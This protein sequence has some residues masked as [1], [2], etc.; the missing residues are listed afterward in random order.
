[1]QLTNWLTTAFAVAMVAGPALAAETD[2]APVE[3]SLGRMTM[4]YTYYNR[5]G[6]EL[7][8]HD[9]DVIA[10]AADAARMLSVDEAL[11]TG[12]AQGLV[13]ALV[14]GAIQNAAHRGA[15]AAGL[16]NCMVVRGWR[17]VKLGDDEGQ[18]LA[19]LPQADLAAR[20][21]PWI[22]AAVP[23]GQIVRVWGNDAANA[24][25]HRYAMRP[26]HTNNGQL[27]LAEATTGD[28]HQFET[29]GRPV[30]SARAV[31]DPKWPKKALTA[32]TL[33]AAPN[34]SGILM[35]RI[36]GLSL[37]NGIGVWLSREGADKDIFPSRSDHGPDLL[38]AAKGL[39][40]AHH[41]GDMFV[42]ATP[43]GRWRLAAIGMTPSL[44]LCLGSPSFAVGAGEVVYA[45][46]FDLGAADF[47]PDLDL[48][49]AKA[50]LAG[51]PQAQTVRA[52][53]WVNG[54]RGLCDG[55]GMYALEFK[56]A[57]FEPGYAWGGAL[58]AAGA[59]APVAAPAGGAP[60]AQAAPADPVH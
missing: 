59:S 10:C 26:D 11:H 14:G 25:T 45:G 1:M 16:E 37:R 56:G 41:D 43:P 34:G 3:F 60:T 53:E 49:P 6:A 28:L 12:A 21:A 27:S 7:K 58:A 39:L 19:K 24:V 47:S 50:W 30:D 2:S 57:P 5:P 38:L 31:L 18:A 8:A 44:S 46:T 52:A 40:F 48:A 22:G 23:H 33:S 13:G 15:V 36:R 35:V 42:I 29:S 55:N 17:V 32:S 51:Q 54:S 9:A 4:G 20:L